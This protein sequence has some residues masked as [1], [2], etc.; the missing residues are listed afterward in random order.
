MAIYHVV[1]VDDL[2]KHSEDSAVPC[3]CDPKVQM[4]DGDMILVHNSYDGREMI[5]E[6]TKILNRRDN[7]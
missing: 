3:D 7:G 5:E 6:A 2:K 4:E 1:P